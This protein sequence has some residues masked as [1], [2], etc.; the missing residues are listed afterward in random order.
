MRTPKFGMNALLL[1]LI[2]GSAIGYFFSVK[3]VDFSSRYVANDYLLIED[4]EY[5]V[6]YS[7]LLPNGIYRGKHEN[8]AELVTEGYFGYDWGLAF[9]GD[10]LIANEYRNTNLGVML[11]DL[12]RVDLTTGKKTV[13]SHDTV[14]RG[15]CTSG[16]LVCVSGLMMESNSPDTNLLCPFYQLTGRDAGDGAAVISYL[17]RSTGEVLFSVRGENIPEKAFETRY[18]NRTLEEVKG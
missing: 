11:C 10:S 6:R 5:A 14:L 17:D 9:N 7:N 4:S 18:L 3:M 2:I 8:T 13:L 16:E 1:I 15:R 12:V